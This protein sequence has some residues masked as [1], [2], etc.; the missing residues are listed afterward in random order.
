MA[1]KEYRYISREGE[2]QEGPLSMTQMMNVHYAEADGKV[3]KYRFG[4]TGM[5]ASRRTLFPKATL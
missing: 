2:V 5:A 1:A 3:F 4:P